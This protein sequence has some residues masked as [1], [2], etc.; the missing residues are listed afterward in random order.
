M[1]ERYIETEDFLPLPISGKLYRINVN[2]VVIDARDRELEYRLDSSQQKTV[3]LDWIDGRREYKIS[4]LIAFTFKPVFIPV[5]LW[6]QLDVMYVDGDHSNIYPSNLVWKFPIGLESER[7]PGYAFIPCYSRYVINKQGEIIQYLTGTKYQFSVNTKGYVVYSLKPDV[8]KYRTTGRHRLLCLAWKEYP[9]DVDNLHVN[10]INEIPGSDD[11]DNLEWTTPKG[12]NHHSLLKR[13]LKD[14]EL[15]ELKDH[16][17]GNIRTFVSAEELSELLNLSGALISRY[18]NSNDQ[19]ILPGGY[20]IKHSKNDWIDHDDI[21]TKLRLANNGGRV[22]VRNVYT[23]EVKEFVS[24]MACSEY[25]GLS[26]TTVAVR[27]RKGG[28]LVFKGGLQFKRKHDPSPWREI[29]DINA[30]LK[31]TEFDMP[32]FCKDVISGEI[33]EF[34]SLAKAESFTKIIYQV[35]KDRA[36]LAITYPYLKYEFS[37]SNNWREYNEDQFAI[38]KLAIKNNTNLIRDFGYKLTDVE[39][40]EIMYYASTSGIIEALGIQRCQIG[41]IVRNK[42]VFRNKYTIER[43]SLV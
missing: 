31:R 23:N 43:I 6:K 22:L 17:T 33:W 2:G 37:Y 13:R 34:S 30:E 25:Y 7:Y 26:S 24:A 38:I 42:K 4:L 35:I 18:L 14:D 20:Q 36:D 32:V 5:K 15:I 9:S 11:L 10:H 1:F 29:T 41:H 16:N 3:F 19:R 12:N 40:K 28:Q 21:E 27:L 8:G 39:T